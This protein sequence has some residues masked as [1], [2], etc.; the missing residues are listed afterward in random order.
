[1]NLGCNAA[2]KREPLENLEGISPNPKENLF[3][4]FTNPIAYVL[5]SAAGAKAVIGI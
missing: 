1:M 3:R 2:I 4:S 5:Q